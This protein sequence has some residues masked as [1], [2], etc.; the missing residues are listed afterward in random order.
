MKTRKLNYILSISFIVV[1]LTGCGGS[2]GDSEVIS[3][4]GAKGGVAGTTADSSTGAVIPDV[5]VTIASNT[6][7]SGAD[8]SY[9]LNNVS[10]GSKSITA[11][12]S[13][14]TDY[15]DTV[16]IFDEQITSHSIVINPVTTSTG[17]PSDKIAAYWNMDLSSISSDSMA[18]QVG[19]IN[20]MLGGGVATGLGMAGQAIVLDGIN[21]YIDFGDVLDEVFAGE[22][23]KLS[24]TMWLNSTSTDNYIFLAKAGDT[25]CNP[26]DNQRQFYLTLWDADRFP[27]FSYTTLASASSGHAHEL[28][29]ITTPLNEW[30]YLAIT[31]DGTVDTSSSDRV[32]IYVNDQSSTITNQSVANFPFSM[33]DGTAHLSLGISIDSNGSPCTD[34]GSTF[35]E[36]MFDE[37]AIWNDALTSEEVEL[38]RQQGLGGNPLVN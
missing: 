5:S 29:N 14:Y 37:L 9:A 1:A 27:S 21:D 6:V 2:G 20:G 12:K 24:I 19:G 10:A 36:G 18:S 32:N 31:Y 30:V 8:G 22:D 17:I 38:I 34:K 13:G 7:M 28:S 11:S 23:K 15:S 25:G 33:M 35:F 4:P 3:E 16:T 26:D